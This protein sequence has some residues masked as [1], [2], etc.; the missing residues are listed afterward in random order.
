MAAV[1][2]MTLARILHENNRVLQYS[3]GEEVGPAWLD[4]PQDQIDS[5]VKGIQLA[6]LGQNPRALH[7]SWMKDKLE[8]GWVY[9]EVKDSEKKTHPYLV[10]Y[11]EL[12]KEQQLKDVLFYTTVKQFV[13]LNLLIIDSRS[14]MVR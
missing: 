1:N 12:P 2:I 4:A 13:D 14:K 6:A 7:G 10:A 5:T 3:A 8:A 11:D 9:G